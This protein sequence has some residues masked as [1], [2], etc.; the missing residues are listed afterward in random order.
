MM[1]WSN[2]FNMEVYYCVC[3]IITYIIGYFVGRYTTKKELNKK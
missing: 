2:I 1:N 3:T